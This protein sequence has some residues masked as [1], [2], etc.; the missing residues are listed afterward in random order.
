MCL[1]THAL[2]FLPLLKGICFVAVSA[3]VEGGV[4]SKWWEKRAVGGASGGRSQKVSSFIEST[5]GTVTLLLS[6]S[7]Y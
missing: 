5:R 3:G 2:L 4:K 7:L 1:G 6:T